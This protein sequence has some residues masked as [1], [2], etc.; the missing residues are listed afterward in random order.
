MTPTLVIFAKA[1]QAGQVKRRLAA[2]IGDV[3]AAQLYRH[4]LST[5]VR[6]L[7]ND[8]RWKTIL[9][10]TPDR[11]ARPLAV[12]YNI[13]AA[14][15]AGGDL[16]DR[17]NRAMQALPPGP[18]V[19]IGSDIPDIRPAHIQQ[20]FKALGDHD[21]VFGPGE[22]GGYWLVGLRRRPMIPSIFGDVRWSTEHALNDTLANFS[23]GAKIATLETL[24]DID[25]G[26]DYFAWRRR[27]FGMA[28]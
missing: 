15:Q 27:T 3:S 10:V 16:G 11:A 20:A 18:V 2:A 12:H 28:G 9:A 22:D 4:T 25:T 26:G 1:P 19:I 6:R 5:M 24:N 8:P 21:A 13:P 23:D 14:P 7:G 17:M